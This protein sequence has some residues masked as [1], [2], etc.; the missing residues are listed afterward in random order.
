M[1]VTSTPLEVRDVIQL[2]QAYKPAVMKVFRNQVHL[3]WDREAKEIKWEIPPRGAFY[4]KKVVYHQLSYR[5]LGL[6]ELIRPVWILR[7][8][9]EWIELLPPEE[10]EALF[11]KYV[12]HDFERNP[13]RP[14][15]YETLSYDEIAQRMGTTKQR[16][17]RLVRRGLGK[18]LEAVNNE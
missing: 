9:D 2:L 7:T 1:M 12:N 14:Y 5:V 18:I 4:S 11:W 3:Y 6:E 10:A 17:W 15:R 8:V 16:V 13:D